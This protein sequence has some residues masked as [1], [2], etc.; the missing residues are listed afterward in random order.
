MPTLRAPSALYAFCCAVVLLETGTPKQIHD[1][2]RV[3]EKLIR[4]SGF[5]WASFRP[6]LVY[7]VGDYRHTAPLLR[8]CA[9]R[10]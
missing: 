2:K 7:G 3:Q 6:T 1:S 9:R 4:G 10:R 8:R 5:E